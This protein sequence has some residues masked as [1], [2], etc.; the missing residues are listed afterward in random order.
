MSTSLDKITS[1]SHLNLISKDLP[2]LQV[3]DDQEEFESLQDSW[4]E[5]TETGDFTVFQT[6]DWNKAWWKFFGEGKKLHIISIKDKNNSLI[7]LAPFFWDTL[8]LGKNRMYSCLRF[9]G[10][11]VSQP[12]GPNLMGLHPYSDYLDLIIKPGYEELATALLV[13]YFE[14]TKLDFSEIILDEIPEESNIWKHLLPMLRNKGYEYEIE[15]SSVCPVIELGGTWDEYQ[16]SLS[17]KQRYNNN[18]A[19]RMVDENSKKGFHIKEIASLEDLHRG[20]NLLVEL[21]QKRWNQLGF[22]GAFAEKRMYDFLKE[23]V[24]SFY[25]RGWVQIRTAESVKEKGNVIAVDLLFEFKRCTYL[26][27]RALDQDSYYSKYGPGNVLLSV[28]IK[29][30]TEKKMEEL[31]FLR[32][33]EQFKFRTANNVVTNKKVTIQNPDKNGAMADIMKNYIAVKR[34]LAIEWAQIQLFVKG[35]TLQ[36]GLKGYVKFLTNRLKYKLDTPSKQ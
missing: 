20:F 31:D 4:Q 21:H 36:P 1:A 34:R 26:V 2:Y 11:S 24:T 5:L 35:E 12:K 30:A 14:E 7:A 27:H 16:N 28:A 10:S 18:R 22:P 29:S 25:E 33:E 17:K 19:L 8:H 32:G 9:L 23:V 6:F 13:Q 3:I 15:K